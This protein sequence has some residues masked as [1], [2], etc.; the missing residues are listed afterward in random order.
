MRTES[1]VVK[2]SSERQAEKTQGQEREAAREHEDARTEAPGAPRILEEI[3][4]E[5]LAIDGICGVY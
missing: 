4:V 5:E 3:C 2:A 1:D